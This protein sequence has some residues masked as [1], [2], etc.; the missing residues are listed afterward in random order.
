LKFCGV[1]VEV[2]KRCT[3]CGKADVTYIDKKPNGYEALC[4]SCAGV[5]LKV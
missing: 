2:E 1:R 4:G 3:R 5:D